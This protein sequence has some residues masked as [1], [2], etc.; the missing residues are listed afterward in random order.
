MP[1]EK[2]VATV[3]GLRDR[4]ER[5]TIVIAA[6]YR[7]LSVSEIAALR[8][9]IRD[10]GVE[11]RVVKNRLFLRAAG[12]A[13]QPGLSELLEGPTA[14]L[15][16]YEDVSA[17]AKVVTEY[18]RTARNAFAVRSGMMDGQLLSAVEILDLASLPTR[19][20][21]LGLL[22]GLLQAPVTQLAGLL[23]GS[24]RNLAGLLD[25]RAK[26][27]EEAQPVAEAPIAT[28]EAS[29][30]EQPAVVA[31]AAAEP[32]AATDEPASE[33]PPAN[34]KPPAEETAAAEQPDTEEQPANE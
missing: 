20:V 17:S 21:L 12:E 5:A 16:G 24:M 15:F 8:K 1:N 34:E 4:I 13:Q 26:Q 23:K 19:P 22:A 2:K 32:P 31:E 30:A 11:M 18:A 10:A 29:A 6:E 9:S 27:L 7:G 14:V 28:A 33:T 25:S 3:K